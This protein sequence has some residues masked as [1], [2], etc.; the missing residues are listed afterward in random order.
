M[1]KMKP[2][3]KSRRSNF[4]VLEILSNVRYCDLMTA[5]KLSKALG[6]G[7]VQRRVTLLFFTC[8]LEILT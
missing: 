8:D 1:T 5:Y 2:W 3:R 6:Y 4:Y 7:N